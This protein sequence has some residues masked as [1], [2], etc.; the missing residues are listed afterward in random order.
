MD[1]Q[2][3]PSFGR[4]LGCSKPESETE[5]MS[6]CSATESLSSDWATDCLAA[7]LSPMI[8]LDE[9]SEGAQQSFAHEAS[10][11]DSESKS[12]SSGAMCSF[13][14]DCLASPFSPLTGIDALR[15]GL[16]VGEGFSSGS[17]SM[18]DSSSSPACSGAI[19]EGLRSASLVTDETQ[20]L[21]ELQDELLEIMAS[22]ID[23]GPSPFSPITFSDELGCGGDRP[24]SPVKRKHLPP[25]PLFPD[26]ESPEK[27]LKKYRRRINISGVAGRPFLPKASC[28]E[29]DKENQNPRK[30]TRRTSLWN[31]QE[32]DKENQRPMSVANLDTRVATPRPTSRR[33]LGMLSPLR[34]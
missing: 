32:D 16:C 2:S 3:E 20:S 4:T 19:A 23:V 9:L 30:M 15:E 33:I 17:D 12:S 1:C 6:D 13:S 28:M 18:G 29:D 14:S 26:P 11:S 24:F 34:I 27:P 8:F 25:V 7:P 31:D 22:T 5:A 21:R 10:G